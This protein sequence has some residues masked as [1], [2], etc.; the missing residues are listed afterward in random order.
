MFGYFGVVT[1]LLASQLHALHLLSIVFK[2]RYCSA[3]NVPIIGTSVFFL[4]ITQ[5]DSLATSLN[6]IIVYIVAAN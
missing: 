4:L 3:N 1:M 2:A 5:L 6:Y